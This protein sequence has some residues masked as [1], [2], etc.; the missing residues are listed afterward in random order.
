MSDVSLRDIKPQIE[1]EIKLMDGKP[2][3]NSKEKEYY[4]T[5]KEIKKEAEEQE[6]CLSVIEELS[7]G[8][9]SKKPKSGSLLYSTPNLKRSNKERV[10]LSSEHKL[11]HLLNLSASL[12]LK[13][14]KEEW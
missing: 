9:I 10:E 8:K 13:P 14:N 2:Y 1:D 4:L 6:F 5:L 3:L 11:E 7:K 12:M